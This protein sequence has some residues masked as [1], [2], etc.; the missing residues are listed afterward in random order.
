MMPLT[1]SLVLKNEFRDRMEL[2]QYRNQLLHHFVAEGTSHKMR[3]YECLD[4][5]LVHRIDCV[6]HVHRNLQ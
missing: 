1:F 6:G 5:E 3:A 4:I 2:S